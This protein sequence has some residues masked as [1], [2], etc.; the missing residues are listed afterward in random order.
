MLAHLAPVRV[1][2]CSSPSSRIELPPHATP[3][4][5]GSPLGSPAHG[6]EK[7]RLTDICNCNISRHEYLLERS[8]SRGER[9]RFH[10]LLH[11]R[12]SQSST[13]RLE[14]LRALTVRCQLRRVHPHASP[15]SDGGVSAGCSWWDSRSRSPSDG[16]PSR[17]LCR[18]RREEDERTSDAPCRD[19][20]RPRPRTAARTASATPSSKRGDFPGPKRLPSTSCL[21]VRADPPPVPGFRHPGPASD[22]LS[23]LATMRR[24]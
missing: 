10:A 11:V 21:L 22:A 23:P 4:G 14:W 20:A 15:S 3:T 6:S 9:R 18:P 1:P 2:R 13:E 24:D 17:R 19:A 12:W 7:M 16:A 5:T 8:D